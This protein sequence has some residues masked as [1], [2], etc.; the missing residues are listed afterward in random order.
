MKLDKAK[1]VLAAI[2]SA[3]AFSAADLYVACLMSLPGPA[4]GNLQ[5]AIAAL[6][7]YVTSG[8]SI[9]SAE[10]AALAT[11][12]AA[13]CAVWIA[14]AWSLTR[15]GNY[16]TGEEHGS[17]RWGTRREGRR[18]MDVGHPFNN[19][20]LTKHYGLVVEREGHDP[21]TER[22]R[23]VL[24]IG[25]SGSG[26]TRGYVEPNLMQLTGSYFVTD[27]KGTTLS[28]LGGM[29][30][31][32]G[33]DIEVFDTV[34]FASSSHYN[35]I[36]YI[37]GEAGILEFVDC[38]IANTTGDQEHA[39]EKFWEDAERLLYIA[40]IGYLIDHCPKGDRSVPGLLLLLSLA[41]AKE[42]DEDYMS[43][44][45][46]LFNEVETGMR[47][48]ERARAQDGPFDPT[49]R[50]REGERG[51]AFAWARTGEPVRV[52][53]D[54]SLSNYRAFKTAAGKTLKS[55]IISCN[56]R[57]KPLAIKEVSEVLSCDEMGLD[58]LG[59]PGR[60]AV[61][62]AIMSDT[63]ETFSFLTAIMM[64][65]TMNLLCER[66]L[67]EYGGSLPTPVSFL[68]DEFANIGRLPNVENMVAVVRS[69]NMS[70]SII[71]QSIAQ[72]KSRYKDDAQTIVDCC[73]TTLFLGGKSNETNKEISEMIGKETVAML[74]FNE[75]RGT[76]NSSTRNW[77]RQERDL[78]QASEVG[79]LDRTKAIVLIAGA[80]PLLDDKYDIG[81]H[82][83]WPEVY[84]GHEGAEFSSPFDYGAYRKGREAAM[85]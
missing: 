27:P 1:L 60:K 66:A 24:V 20:I 80:D 26:K 48:V 7:G 5:E 34:D 10:P 46:L 76:M 6:P 81:G 9:V 49:L 39:G 11:G 73:D 70:M 3:L 36:S 51:S 65:Q 8:G 19:I 79:K 72:L 47:Y 13:A 59:D 52:E 25:G 17:A 58:T 62:F 22:N 82:P 83:R 57:L 50:E 68:L 69:R 37:E 4:A 61:V 45:D 74:T 28:N 40:L 12:L 14:W 16:R 32:E 78:I 43:P 31:K 30:Q 63:S 18:F 35:P 77:N 75:S 15:E 54:F 42:E 41:K 67:R 85:G 33:Y 38:L 23:N 71:L 29:F 55:I 44:L 21:A 2:G 53:D 64:W 56:V 84:P